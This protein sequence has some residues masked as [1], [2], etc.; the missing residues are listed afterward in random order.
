MK[1]TNLT[2]TFNLGETI[3]IDN[4]RIEVTF[5]E[6]RGTRQTRMC[7]NAPENVLILRK[8]AI[9]SE[10]DRQNASTPNGQ[11]RYFVK[12][13]PQN[14]TYLVVDRLDEKRFVIAANKTDA[15]KVCDALNK[16]DA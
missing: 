6:A 10:A 2:L 5:L 16:A 11:R 9:R 13:N 3:L 7:F 14:L 4:G 1:R 12:Y 8:G 15:L